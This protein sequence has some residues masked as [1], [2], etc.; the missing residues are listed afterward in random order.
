MKKYLYTLNIIDIMDKQDTNRKIKAVID[1]QLIS[2]LLKL[3]VVG[4]THSD[5]IKR[6]FK[7]Q[8]PIESPDR[9][10]KILLDEE[11]ITKMYREFKEVG[12]THSDI[13]KKQLI[14]YIKRYKKEIINSLININ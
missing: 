13:I 1:G 7:M 5:V 9:K 12:E 2:L 4:E 6:I 11:I 14:N 3:R 10:V 8:P